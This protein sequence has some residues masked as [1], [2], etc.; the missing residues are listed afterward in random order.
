LRKKRKKRRQKK[1]DDETDDETQKLTFAS[2]TATQN[3]QEK[4]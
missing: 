3:H 1:V 2:L 4:S